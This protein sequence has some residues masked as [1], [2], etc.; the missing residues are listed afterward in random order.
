MAKQKINIGSGPNRGDGDP[1][2]TAYQKVN[3][4]FDELY[5]GNFAD[6]ENIASS[7]VP[8]LDNTYNLGTETNRW[9][10]VHVSDFIYLNSARIEVTAGGKLLINNQP[11]SQFQDIVGSV[12][13]D[14]STL[15][16]DGVNGKIVGDV[17]YSPSTLNHWTDPVPQTIGDALDRIT[18]AV[19]SL[20][21]GAAI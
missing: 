17:D 6:P 3:Q 1:L 10:D 13:A 8:E 19:Y 9:S 2:R 5:A 14:D 7:I 4:N 21:G 12:F 18:A 16:V 15:L 20:N 11:A